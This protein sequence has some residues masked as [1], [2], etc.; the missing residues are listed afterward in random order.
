M[1]DT[2]E[3]SRQNLEALVAWYRTN[4]GNRNEATTRL[5]M[6]DRLFFECLAW[7]KED[8]TLEEPHGGEYAD[9]VFSV[10]RP[11]LI[12]EAK[13]E[14]DYFELPAGPR[15]LEISLASLMRDFP[16]IKSAV[17]QAAGYC[18]SRG[19]PFGVVSNG[20]QVVAFVANRNDGTPP[21]DGKSIVFD[22]PDSML[23]HFWDFWQAL[24]RPGI[25]EKKLQYRLIGG[26]P[27]IPLKFSAML[28]NYPGLKRRNV[29][30]TDL[31][32]LSEL[33]IEDV[34]RSPD[35]EPEF[36]R[37]CYCKSGALSQFALTSKEILESRYAGLFD[38]DKG[39]SVVPATTKAGFSPDLLGTSIARRPILLL[40]DVGVG[41]S[42]FIRHLINIDAA[43]VFKNAIYLHLDLGSKGA[44]A[45]DL[46][47]HII[48]QIE[49]QLLELYDIDL[50]KGNFVRGV[51]DLEL[52]RF[53]SGIHSELKK[54]APETFIQ[55]EID[56]LEKLVSS[57]EAH[58]EKSLQHI[59]KARK[60]QIIFFLDNADQ[61]DEKTQELAFL[62]GQEM[63]E[64]WPV[65]V[66]V[67]L[68]PTTFHRSKK[69]GA[70]T[71]YHAKAFTIAPPRIDLV[72]KKRL[73]FA[74]KL[75]TGEIPIPSLQRVGVNLG[76][77]SRIIEVV[78]DSLEGNYELIEFVENIAAGNVRMALDLVRDFIGSGHVDTQKILDII[79]DSGRY[80]IPLH[81]FLRAII[82]GDN[83]Y[84]DPTSSPVANLFDISS[85]DPKEHF[86]LPLLLGVLHTSGGAEHR[87]GFVETSSLYDA[88][89]GM[90]FTPDQ[91]D[92]A[93]SRACQ[94]NLA[95]TNA[96][97]LPEPGQQRPTGIRITSKGEY[98]LQKIGSQFQYIDAV[99]VDTPI[100]EKEFR[101]SI[102]DAKNLD[103]R[104]NR[105]DRFVKYLTS[106]WSG[107]GTRAV[108]FNWFVQASAVTSKIAQIRKAVS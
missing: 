35:L 78:K 97:Q 60:K 6:V 98:H 58:V 68:R 77:L 74:L 31:Q 82:Y 64:S 13:R 79:A 44:L 89:Q 67:S 27:D 101:E 38:S 7:S 81:E 66:F 47:V 5:T 88:L 73:E 83:E 32:V 30:Q 96:R 42:T 75:T 90:A 51:Y 50:N 2:Y 45:L 92:T 10:F 40:G 103:E 18:Q 11:V 25:E 56:F 95:E 48:N 105:A 21:L 28:P 53:A 14:G 29:I 76:K 69:I 15:R 12:V 3:R 1:N 102:R 93:V 63:A 4:Q 62:I 26:R 85:L 55:K 16:N 72:L 94:N 108:G 9:Y 39:P 71:G 61:R 34:I 59:S 80:E 52:K 36:L 104:M 23:L 24:S 86:I 84:Y 49:L 46:R 107:V 87:E 20:H 43:E 99:V 106:Q 65:I 37:Q 100:L 54:S 91:V 41:K 17:E 19:V 22:S 70:L 33:V 8:V 57:R